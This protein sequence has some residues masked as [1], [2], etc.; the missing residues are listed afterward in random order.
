MPKQADTRPDW[1]QAHEEYLRLEKLMGE[2][3]THVEQHDREEFG[4]CDVCDHH[5]FDVR[6]KLERHVEQWAS[7]WAEQAA[8]LFYVVLEIDE[9][10]KDEAAPWEAR[11]YQ[12]R[13]YAK[14][15]LEL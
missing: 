11:L 15:V 6:N 3:E 10:A 8:A 5:V 1:L 4:T 9:V 12:I 2:L 13:R 14:E 7:T